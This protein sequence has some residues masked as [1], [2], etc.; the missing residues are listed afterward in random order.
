MIGRANLDGTGVRPSFIVTGAEHVAD[1]TIADGMI[2]WAASNTVNAHGVGSIGRANLNGSGVEPAL[3]A[4]PSPG[5][6]SIAAD[7]THLYWVESQYQALPLYD[8]IMQANLDGSDPRP[9]VTNTGAYSRFGDVAVASDQIYWGWDANIARA[10]VDGS[11]IEPQFLPAAGGIVQAV[12]TH[13]YW[14]SRNR[15]GR[16]NLDGSARVDSFITAHFTDGIAIDGLRGPA[17]KTPKKP[18]GAKSGLVRL[19]QPWI[20]CPAVAPGCTA[21]VKAKAAL[22]NGASKRPIGRS[23]Y[24]VA[25]GK[26]ALAHFKLTRTARKALKQRKRLKATVTITTVHGGQATKRTGKVT[27]KA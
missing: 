27:L 11:A 19:P 5:I 13:V 2:Y 16:A 1:L 26:S 18:T 4:S 17:A 15:I 21:T 25:A 12:G 10:N 3:V 22:K 8:R 24:A 6:G 14:G 9:I 7:A 23:S 20:T